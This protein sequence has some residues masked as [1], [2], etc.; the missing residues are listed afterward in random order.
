[1]IG[2]DLAA[3]QDR[4]LNEMTDKEKTALRSRY[5]AFDHPCAREIVLW[6]DGHWRITDEIV[7]TQ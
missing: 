5:A 7:Q 4:G 6:L 1:M 3:F 2:E